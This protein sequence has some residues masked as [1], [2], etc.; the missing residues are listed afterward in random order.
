MAFL[1]VAGNY[2]GTYLETNNGF[3]KKRKY[4]YSTTHQYSQLLHSSP[5]QNNHPLPLHKG[6]QYLQIVTSQGSLSSYTISWAYIRW[7]ISHMMYGNP[8]PPTT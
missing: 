6:S 2:C 8:C 4:H 7:K 1:L 5:A 3:Y